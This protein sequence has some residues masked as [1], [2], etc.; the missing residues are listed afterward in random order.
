MPV[1]IRIQKTDDDG[2]TLYLHLSGRLSMASYGEFTAYKNHLEGS[3]KIVI[4]M[5]ELEYIDSSALGML[6]ML[7]ERAGAPPMKIEIVN[8]SPDIFGILSTVKFD[9]LFKISREHSR[10]TE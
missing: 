1:K 4:D 3:S 2:H 10:P 6:L 7:R 9:T 8:C 5:S